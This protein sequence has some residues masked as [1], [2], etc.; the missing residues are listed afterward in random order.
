[1]CC[2]GNNA[3]INKEKQVAVLNSQPQKS[4]GAAIKINTKKKNNSIK[5]GGF[6]LTVG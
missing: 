1:M 4:S 3:V 6:G 5:P 2:T